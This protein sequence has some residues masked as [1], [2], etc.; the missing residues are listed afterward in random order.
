MASSKKAATNGK[1][2]TSSRAVMLHKTSGL[3]P[4]RDAARE[5]P[6]AV[7]VPDRA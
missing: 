2:T 5:R 7:A 6:S 3:Q 4:L 1:G